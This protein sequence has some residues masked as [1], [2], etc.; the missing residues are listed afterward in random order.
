MCICNECDD[1]QRSCQRFPVEMSF[2]VAHLR[3]RR[4]RRRRRRVTQLQALLQLV[5]ERGHN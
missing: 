3:S 1:M 2:F 5:G 4:R